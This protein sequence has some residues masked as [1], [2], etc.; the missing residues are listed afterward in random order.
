MKLN[1]FL[2]RVFSCFM[3]RRLGPWW[4]V[5]DA[6]TGETTQERVEEPCVEKQSVDSQEDDLGFI[7]MTHRLENL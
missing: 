5:W 4:R 1:P 7:D 6:L 3:C 2:Q